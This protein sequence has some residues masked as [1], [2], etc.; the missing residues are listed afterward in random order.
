MRLLELPQVMEVMELWRVDEGQVEPR[1]VIL[2]LKQN[3]I[4]NRFY[5]IIS[6][7]Q[8]IIYLINSVTVHITLRYF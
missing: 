4:L 6:R 5:D 8:S 7:T 3:L 2:H 1:V